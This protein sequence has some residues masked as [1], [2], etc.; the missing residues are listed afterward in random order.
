MRLVY[1]RGNLDHGLRDCVYL[2]NLL[3]RA[4]ENVGRSR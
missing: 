4:Q 1:H 2:W 3:A